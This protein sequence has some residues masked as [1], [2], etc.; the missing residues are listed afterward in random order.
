MRSK[1]RG[2]LAQTIV[3]S[4][5]KLFRD[6]AMELQLQC[7]CG[8]VRARLSHM[9]PQTVNRAVC[10]CRFCQSYLRFLGQEATF[11][12]SQ[13]GTDVF[14]MSPRD[15]TF[16]SGFELIRAVKQ[17]EKG[18]ARYYAGCCNTPLFN[19][20]QNLRVPF[21]GVFTGSIQGFEE[22]RNADDAIGPVRARVN[23]QTEEQWAQ[24]NADRMSVLRMLLHVARLMLFWFVRGDAK[25]SPLRADNG[26]PRLSVERIRVKT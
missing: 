5:A 4:K 3:Y 16:E 25:R 26:Q 14:Q 18:A 11:A 15:I 2:D 8:Q 9:Q 7:H 1:I 20:M 19:G 21:L 17:T 13:G 22:L 10:Y 23:K 12:D 6:G 24:P